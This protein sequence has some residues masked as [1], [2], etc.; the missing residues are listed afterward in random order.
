VALS[1]CLR[2]DLRA[3]GASIGVSVLCPSLLASGIADSARNRPARWAQTAEPAPAYFERVRRGMADS[4]ITADDAA[5]ATLQAI[6][7]GSFYVLP[8]DHTW[9]SVERRMRAIGEDHLRGLAAKE[10]HDRR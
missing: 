6:D 9:A 3:A 7:R 5:T 2:H 8:H 10:E 4:S 1:E